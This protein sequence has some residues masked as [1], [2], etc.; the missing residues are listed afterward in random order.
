MS[1]FLLLDRSHIRGLLSLSIL[2][3]TESPKNIILG[4]E[5]NGD[6]LPGVCPGECIIL[7]PPNPGIT[8]P[9]DT[10]SCT[11]VSCNSLAGFLGL[12]LPRPVA[13]NANLYE[14]GGGSLSSPFLRRRVP[15]L[16][17]ITSSLWAIIDAPVR[18]CISSALPEWS[19]WK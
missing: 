7:T 6:M 5:T 17:F 2:F 4:S 13:L 10:V 8:S 19:K 18:L 15:S 9:C 11:G 16:F 12:F 14:R 1:R 3:I